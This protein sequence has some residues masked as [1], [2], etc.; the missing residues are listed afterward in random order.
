MVCRKLFSVRLLKGL[1][2]ARLQVQTG[3]YICT[4]KS[5]QHIINAWHG[6]SVCNCDLVQSAV[7]YAE[8]QRAVL[9]F[10]NIMGAPKGEVL[11]L[12]KRFWSRSVICV[13]ISI[14]S[15]GLEDSRL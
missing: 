13:S 15:F 4:L 9:L 12:M 11:G 14:S 5:V 6:I 3:E 1:V 2:V 7:V 10:T 8:S